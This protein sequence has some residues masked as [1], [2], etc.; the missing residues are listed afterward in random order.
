LAVAVREIGKSQLT[1]LYGY[2]RRKCNTIA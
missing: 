2:N 1:S